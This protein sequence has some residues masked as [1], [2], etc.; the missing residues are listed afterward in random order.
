LATGGGGTEVS[1]GDTEWTL[2]LAAGD[3]GDAA[4]P[5]PPDVETTLPAS[6][7]T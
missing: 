1:F 6:V 7:T 4:A 5:T 2:G 3:T